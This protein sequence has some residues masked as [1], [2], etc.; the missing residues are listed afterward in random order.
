MID[1][2]L[3]E[4]LTKVRQV[5]DEL[6]LAAAQIVTEYDGVHRLR[7]ALSKWYNLRAGIHATPKGGQQKDE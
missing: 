4:E 1:Q 6:A 3:A 2:D 7:A 5:G